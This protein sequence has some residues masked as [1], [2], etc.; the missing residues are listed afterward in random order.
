MSWIKQLALERGHIYS[1]M[2]SVCS[3]ML[4]QGQITHPAQT[5]FDSHPS[6]PHPAPCQPPMEYF[7]GRRDATMQCKA[8]LWGRNKQ[9][10]P[11]Q[12]KSWCRQRPVLPLTMFDLT[13]LQRVTFSASKYM[14][15]WTKEAMNYDTN[16]SKIMKITF[17][18]DHRLVARG[19][20]W[21]HWLHVSLEAPCG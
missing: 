6:Q 17:G 1:W 15:L 13:A 8:N 18:R 20:F 2:V 12:I 16:A 14:Q 19:Q 3:W 21:G 7:K 10:T 11:W 5:K 9:S 4:D